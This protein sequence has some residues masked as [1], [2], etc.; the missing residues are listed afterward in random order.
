[1]SFLKRLFK[2]GP[3]QQASNLAT[4][5]SSP[6]AMPVCWVFA[7]YDKERVQSLAMFKA[8]FYSEAN[9][10]SMVRSNLRIPDFIEVQYVS[11]AAW[12]APDI[13]AAQDSF[14]CDMDA[15]DAKVSG[16]LVQCGYS[17]DKPKAAMKTTLPYPNA[18]LLLIIV[19]MIP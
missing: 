14:D 3:A 8:D 2:K 15:I 7:C 9:A 11:P 1:M 10:I 18:G 13:T 6:N 12:N 4:P 19:N 17:A 16:H 5:S